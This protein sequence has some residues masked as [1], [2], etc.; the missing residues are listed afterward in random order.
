MDVHI[1]EDYLIIAVLLNV[2]N[3]VIKQFE[4]LY[5]NIE[6]KD[7]ISFSSSFGENI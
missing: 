7:F 2:A 5:P 3:N 4:E 1:W 6:Y